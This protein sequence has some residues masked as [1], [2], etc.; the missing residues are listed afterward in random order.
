MLENDMG[1]LEAGEFSWGI[2]EEFNTCGQEE[3]ISKLLQERK[4]A[5]SES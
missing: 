5:P 3:A 4:G 1:E 2:T